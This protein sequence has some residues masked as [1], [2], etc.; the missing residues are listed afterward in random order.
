MPAFGMLFFGFLFY[1]DHIKIRCI[2]VIIA[3]CYGILSLS[4]VQIYHRFSCYSITTGGLN[5]I[6][7]RGLTVYGY[8]ESPF[9]SGTTVQNRLVHSALRHSNSGN[10]Q[11]ILRTMPRLA[12]KNMDI[13]MILLLI[14]SSMKM[15]RLGHKSGS[16]C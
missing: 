3:K 5:P 13:P 15:I 9:L 14:S 6:N 7:L 16:T 4:Q 1:C 10:R 12:I 11:G 8:G 2:A